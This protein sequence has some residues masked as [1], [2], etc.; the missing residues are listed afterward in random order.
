MDHPNVNH[1]DHVEQLAGLIAAASATSL[2]VP[3][4]APAESRA[5][6]SRVA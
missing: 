2:L 6:A 1:R 4:R 3:G 5:A